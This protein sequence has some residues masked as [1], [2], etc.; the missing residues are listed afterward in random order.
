[1]HL[2][3]PS[4]SSI[5]LHELPALTPCGS[6]GFASFGDVA[7]VQFQSQPGRVACG[8]LLPLAPSC[9]D[10]IAL[11]HIVEKSRA[12]SGFHLQHDRHGFEN[13]TVLML[14]HG[15]PNSI[16]ILPRYRGANRYAEAIAEP[17]F[18][19][20]RDASADRTAFNVRQDKEEARL[21]FQQYNTR[22]EHGRSV[23]KTGR[24]AKSR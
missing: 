2:A 19:Q 17:P 1:M 13:G 11:S 10:P 23:V 7:G 3:R 8:L 18:T 21:V 24:A 20:L 12:R 4:F 15:R 6:S 5:L 22:T 14:R 16:S 9:K